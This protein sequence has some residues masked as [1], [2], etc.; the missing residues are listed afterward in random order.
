MGVVYKRVVLAFRVGL[1]FL[2]A[3]EKDRR[4]VLIGGVDLFPDK[5]H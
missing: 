5:A 4:S 3:G 1:R 2:W